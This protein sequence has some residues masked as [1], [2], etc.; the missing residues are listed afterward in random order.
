[1]LWA[2]AEGF[3]VAKVGKASVRLTAVHSPES[4]SS[5]LIDPRKRFRYSLETHASH[6]CT[7]E[8]TDVEPY[9]ILAAIRRYRP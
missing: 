8:N 6:I 3:S 7:L 4:S 9:Q 2:D 1:M 5:I